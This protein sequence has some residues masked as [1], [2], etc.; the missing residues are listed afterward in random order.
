[1]IIDNDFIYFRAHLPP[2]SSRMAFCRQ[3][4][5]DFTKFFCPPVG[6]LAESFKSY[7]DSFNVGLNTVLKDMF[8]LTYV[9]RYNSKLILFSMLSKIPLPPMMNTKPGIKNAYP[10][11]VIPNGN[12]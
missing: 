1:M 10:K 3:I 12:F 6:V 4:F 11:Q 7:Q 5:I 2:L 8:I 9:G